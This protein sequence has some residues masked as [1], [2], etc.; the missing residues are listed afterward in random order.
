MYVHL[1]LDTNVR[2]KN[3]VA[4]IDLEATTFSKITKNFFEIAQKEGVVID[5]SEGLPRSAIVCDMDG[6]N[7]VITTHLTSMTLRKRMEK[8]ELGIIDK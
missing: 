6:R 1:G 4:V 8:R 5:V 7:V 3:I 2:F